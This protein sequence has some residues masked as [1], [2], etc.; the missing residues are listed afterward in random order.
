MCVTGV[1][2]WLSGK[3]SPSSCLCCPPVSAASEVWTQSASGGRVTTSLCL[4]GTSKSIGLNSLRKYSGA[5]RFEYYMS[6]MYFTNFCNAFPVRCRV[7]YSRSREGITTATYLLTYFDGSRVV[8]GSL[9]SAA[10]Y[11]Q[12]PLYQ[13]IAP[14]FYVL[15]WPH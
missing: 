12:P 5:Y 8:R 9:S 6:F 14:D 10:V 13:K 15:R 4:W 11:P 2:R 1:E 7:G 3:H